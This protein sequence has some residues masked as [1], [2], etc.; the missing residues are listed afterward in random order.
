MCRQANEGKKSTFHTQRK[1]TR[2]E[3][4]RGASVAVIAGR[5]IKPVSITTNLRLLYVFFLRICA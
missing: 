2:R 4:R 5:R 1:K 3:I